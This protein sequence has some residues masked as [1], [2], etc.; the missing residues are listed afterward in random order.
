MGTNNNIDVSFFNVFNNL[1][2]INN[3][4]EEVLNEFG[5]PENIYNYLVENRFEE[6][7]VFSH[8]DVSLPNLFTNNIS[9]S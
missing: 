8:G 2:D 1:L 9:C 4:S 6:E 3:I 5:S 7:L